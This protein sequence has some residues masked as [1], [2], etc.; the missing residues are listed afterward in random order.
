MNLHKRIVEAYG[1]AD[2]FED[3]W[4]SDNVRNSLVDVGPVADALW[5]A[6]QAVNRLGR[7]TRDDDLHKL[8]DDLKAISA[9]FA[10]IT[11]NTKNKKKKKR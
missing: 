2:P 4:N 10:K 11:K 8:Y 6:Q 3:P 7:Q 9:K 1:L 5:K